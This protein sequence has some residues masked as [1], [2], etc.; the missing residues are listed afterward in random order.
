M[1]S[2]ERDGMMVPSD[3]DRNLQPWQ[4]IL[5]YLGVL[6]VGIALSIYI[7]DHYHVGDDR[8]IGLALGPIFLL[9]ATG[10]PWWLYDTIRRVRWFGL[11]RNETAMHIVLAVIGGLLVL[12]GVG[13]LS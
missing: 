4:R 1:Q 9:A 6:V 12:L 5:I 7:N 13:V 10:W 2:N 3:Q 8:S 11:I